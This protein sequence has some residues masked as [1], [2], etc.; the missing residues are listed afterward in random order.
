[1]K[2]HRL[3]L[4]F[5]LGVISLSISSDAFSASNKPTDK[6]DWEKDSSCTSL[7]DD[8][9]CVRKKAVTDWKK[10]LKLKSG[11][12]KCSD[13]SKINSH[14][15]TLDTGGADIRVPGV[16]RMTRT[17]KAS[18]PK[19]KDDKSTANITVVEVGSVSEDKNE[20]L[21]DSDDTIT[22]TAKPNPTGEEMSSIEWEL[23]FNDGDWESV[24][25]GETVTL[26]GSE[27]VGKYK[28]KARNGSGDTWKESSIVYVKECIVTTKRLHVNSD[29]TVQ[30]DVLENNGYNYECDVSGLSSLDWRTWSASYGKAD[31]TIE[32][33]SNSNFST[34]Y[35]WR[36]NFGA[37]PDGV[38][39]SSVS[40][41]MN[42]DNGEGSSDDDE[43]DVIVHRPKE[44]INEVNPTYHR[45]VSGWKYKGPLGAAGDS[46]TNLTF[47]F[48]TSPSKTTNFTIDSGSVTVNA[49]IVSACLNFKPGTARQL[50]TT[51]SRS[52]TVNNVSPGNWYGFWLI[53]EE[54]RGS[55]DIKLW[56]A[57]GTSQDGGSITTT[58]YEFAGAP[59]SQACSSRKDCS[60]YPPEDN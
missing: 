54:L 40:C 17:C 23:Q 58:D 14:T 42:C 7:S 6:C 2:I 44:L 30:S 12:D 50:S 36:I 53:V 59:G 19:L 39:N 55:A 13:C 4:F 11:K 35:N 22:I 56:S 1:M 9:I 20:I 24:S 5:I 57:D 49:A 46:A 47:T 10:Y 45:D 26:A 38:G 18:R 31:G 29:W 16:Y 33:K 43:I 28:Y 25:G 37:V 8:I 21:K 51:N 3:K 60:S 34:T 41:M 32:N 27:E 15:M 52:A 48:T